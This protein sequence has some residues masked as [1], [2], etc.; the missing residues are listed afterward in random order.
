MT[1]EMTREEMLERASLLCAR[2]IRFFGD[3]V[4]QEVEALLR[5]AYGEIQRL[6]AQAATEAR[7]IET[8]LADELAGYPELTAALDRMHT[9]WKK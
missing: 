4:P 3:L 6:R 1:R 9:S 2:P 8:L 5:E 7:F